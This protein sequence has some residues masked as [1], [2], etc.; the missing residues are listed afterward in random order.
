MKKTD[1]LVIGSGPGGFA[2]AVEAA[3]RGAS[4][5]L[6]EKSGWGG[7]CT[8]R[9]CIP[10]KALLAGSKR[11]DETKKIGRLGIS[12]GEVGFDFPALR[13]HM[14]QMVRV[15][16]LGTKKSL[17][18]AGVDILEG[19]AILKSPR[20]VAIERPGAGT[21]TVS[22]ER[23]VIAWGSRSS[24]PAGWGLSDRVVTSTGFLA[25]K[26]LPEKAIVVGGG[27]IGLEFATFLAELGKTVTVVE[28]LDQIL[29]G[30][31]SDAARFLEGELKKKGVRFHTSARVDTIEETPAGV[32]LTATTATGQV[33]LEG[34]LVLLATGR[35]PNLRKAELDRLS[36]AHDDGGIHID[37]KFETSVPGIHAVGDV[38]GGLLLAHRAMAQG[39]A[40]AATLFGESFPPHRDGDVPVAVYTH[41]GFGRVGITEGEARRRGLSVSV[42][43]VEYGANLTA[44]TELLGP[45]FVK[46][47]FH[48]NRLAGVTV[49]GASAA[50]L[51]GAVSLPVTKRMA[52]K[53]LVAWVLPH[54]TLGEILSDFYR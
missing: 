38:T 11:Y 25:R 27:A 13:K 41:P 14:E 6:A 44:R 31:D 45:G 23:I 8:H 2:A 18:E 29:P 24:R 3:R 32:R 9:G 22:C 39:R 33:I 7:T 48:E 15:S 20:E 51:I 53:D 50:E 35:S 26:E 42:Q 47:L 37:E 36:I 12:F 21:E 5:T 10:T 52:K 1:L 43:R 17:T 40:L 28:L 54:P 16:A 49:V 46:S 34:D 30:E 19:E 4:V